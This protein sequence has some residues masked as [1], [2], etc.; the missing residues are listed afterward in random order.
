MEDYKSN[1]IKVML[2]FDEA[3]V[4]A[5]R[6]V[7][8]DPDGKDMYDVLC[9]C[10]NLFLSFPLFVIYLS[11]NSNLSLLAPQGP[12]A[13]SARARANAD[14]LQAPI[15]ETPFDCAPTLRI[16]PNKLKLEDLYQIEFMAQFGRPM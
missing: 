8:G 16:K 13:R 15:T 6:K 10:F 3:H 11:T 14:A 9:S 4:L 5:D 7:P 12:L 1:E 2:Y